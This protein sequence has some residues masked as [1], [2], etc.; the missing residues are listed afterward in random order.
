MLSTLVHKNGMGIT[1]G[2]DWHGWEKRKMGSFRVPARAL[3]KTDQ[4]LKL[5][6]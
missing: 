3:Y 5:L 6:D 2:S 1:G 4:A